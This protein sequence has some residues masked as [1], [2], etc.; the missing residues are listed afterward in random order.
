VIIKIGHLQTILERVVPIVEP[1]I[2][3]H[4]ETLVCWPAVAEV[5][6]HRAEIS[7]RATA[8]FDETFV[9]L[10]PSKEQF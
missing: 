4:L 8:L 9:E 1:S 10:D 3:R 2:E 5:I 7:Q 6:H